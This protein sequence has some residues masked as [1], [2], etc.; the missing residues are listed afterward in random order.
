M[1]TWTFVNERG[2]RTIKQNLIKTWSRIGQ[3][4]DS[5]REKK[6]SHNQNKI[7]HFQYYFLSCYRWWFLKNKILQRN[8]LKIS[9]K[10]TNTLTTFSWWISTSW[11]GISNFQKKRKTSVVTIVRKQS[12]NVQQRLNRNLGRWL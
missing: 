1:P 3:V 11:A 9:C 6:T 7:H 8:G 12:L 5:T 2:S 4:C 10:E